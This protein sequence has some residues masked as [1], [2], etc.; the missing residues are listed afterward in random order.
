MKPARMIW[1]IWC[2]LWVVF[3]IAAMSR[4]LAANATCGQLLAPPP[5]CGVPPVVP[6]LQLILAGMSGLAI[7]LPVGK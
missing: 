2:L 6:P 4:S 1:I 5:H 7:L 3:W